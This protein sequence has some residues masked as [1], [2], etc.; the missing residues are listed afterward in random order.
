MLHRTVFLAKGSWASSRRAALSTVAKVSAKGMDIISPEIGLDGDRLE[1]YNLART[2]A[3]NELRPHASKWDRESHF[4]VETFKKLGELG[5][6]GIFVQEDVGGTALSRVDAVSII[7]GLATGCVGT[8][9]MLTIHNMCTATV[10]K[11]GN[12]AQRQEW[13]PKLAKMDLLVSFCLTESGSGSDAASLITKAE[14]DP[15]TNEY[16]INGSKVF[17]SGAG[18]SDLY[19]VMCRTSPKSISCI[20]VPKGTPGLSFGQKEEKMGWNVQP[21]RQVIMEDVRVPVGNRLGAEGEG[22]K[23]AMSGLDGGRLSIGAC[24]L[25][26]AQACFEIAL[27]YTKERKQFGKAIAD[28]QSTQF[29][30]ADMAGKILSSRLM[31][32]HAAEL[33][34][35]GHPAASA[36]CAL[37]KRMATDQGE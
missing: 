24:S 30:F 22:F 5:L 20:V 14:I 11:F 21:T 36:H 27:K 17:I 13:V 7:E 2:F 3:D 15:A 18:L 37:A 23:I 29:K 34:D 28:F 10:D 26:A 35:Q 25:G 6:G 31:L 33:L 9:A 16:V 32:R 19:L 12:E 8:T 4:P 1:F